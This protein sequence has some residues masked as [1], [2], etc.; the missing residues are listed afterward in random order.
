MLTIMSRIDV[1]MKKR[2]E[3]NNVTARVDEEGWELL[4]ILDEL[5]SLSIDAKMWKRDALID[6]LE[7]GELAHL[8]KQSMYLDYKLAYGRK[9][10]KHKHEAT[11]TVNI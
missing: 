3:G 4:A 9:G 6:K 2:T 5:K 1:D 8:I 10:D 11:A 7:L